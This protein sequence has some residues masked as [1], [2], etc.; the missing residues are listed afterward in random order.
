MAQVLNICGRELRSLFATPTAYVLFAVYLVFAGFVFT[1][2]LRI[3]L[4]QVEQVQAI[5]QY[6]QYLE[7]FANLNL[8]VIA[9]ALGTF[10]ILFIILIPFLTMR[11]FA[12]ERANGTIELLLT[13][14]VSTWQIVLGKY[15]AVLCWVALFVAAGGAFSG[16]LFVYGNPELGWTLAGHLGIFL[17]GAALAAIGCFVSALTRSPIIAGVVGLIASLLLYMVGFLAGAV[18]NPTLAGP[19][20]YLALD[21]HV[22]KSLSGLLRL[23]DLVYFGVLIVLFLTLARTALESLRWR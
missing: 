12:E 10:I 11:A 16:L 6:A 15:L 1:G 7:L 20:R 23:Q 8:R 18:E 3:F 2:S 19:I 21:S 9:P 22:D 5:P 14:P 4:E 13:S 17:L